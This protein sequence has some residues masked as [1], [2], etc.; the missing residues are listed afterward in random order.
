LFL[1]FFM[2]EINPRFCWLH[3]GFGLFE[4]LMIWP[5]KLNCHHDLIP[6]L[7]FVSRFFLLMSSQLLDHHQQG[8]K[9]I[10]GNV[11]LPSI[12]A[13]R[14]CKVLGVPKSVTYRQGQ[15]TEWGTCPPTII[16]RYP[17]FCPCWSPR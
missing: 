6:V 14:E 2:A 10:L 8:S 5:P 16:C 17:V 15:Q 1:R 7:W 4:A 9:F 12:D 13:K 3:L 11:F